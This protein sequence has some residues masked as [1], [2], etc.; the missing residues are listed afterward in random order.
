MEENGSKFIMEGAVLGS[1]AE[2]AI[3]EDNEE[4]GELS[5]ELKNFLKGVI[6]MLTESTKCFSNPHVGRSPGDVIRDMV[7]D[8]A[9]NEENDEEME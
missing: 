4:D 1:E 5:P 3:A 9:A 7:R 8:A 6:D 2:K